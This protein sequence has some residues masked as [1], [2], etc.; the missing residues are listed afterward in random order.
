MC[1]IDILKRNT[2]ENVLIQ[3]ALMEMDDLYYIKHSYMLSCLLAPGLN[4]HLLRLND[5][6]CCAAYL[7]LLLLFCSGGG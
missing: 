7:L 1:I 3:D 2:Y 6:T 5:V 4:G